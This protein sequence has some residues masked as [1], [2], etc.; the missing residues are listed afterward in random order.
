MYVAHS[1]WH[2]HTGSAVRPWVQ[3]TPA[4]T[5]SKQRS[6]EVVGDN[7][8]A[9]YNAGEHCGPRWRSYVEVTSSEIETKS[10]EEESLW[11]LVR[12]HAA[13]K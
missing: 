11:A 1:K 4:I 12:L 2:R 7:E 6:V 9:I 5:K 3:E 8:L 10:L 13:E